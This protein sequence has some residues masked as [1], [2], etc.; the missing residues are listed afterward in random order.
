MAQLQ[1]IDGTTTTDIDTI[2]H[3]LASLHVRLAQWPI[4]EQVIALLSKVQLTD[5]E[6]ETVSAAHDIYFS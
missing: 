2:Q 1:F 4:Q 3:T 5:T 6:K